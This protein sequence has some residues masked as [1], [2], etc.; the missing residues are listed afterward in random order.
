MMLII[1]A[2]VIDNISGAIA[3]NMPLIK[4]NMPPMKTILFFIQS[5]QIQ[6]IIIPMILLN[7][8]NIIT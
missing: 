7:I 8:S 3:V 1:P 5:S 6:P 2:T 4:N